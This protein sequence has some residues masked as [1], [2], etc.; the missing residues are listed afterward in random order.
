MKSVINKLQDLLN[1]KDQIWFDNVC[2]FIGLLS[3]ITAIASFASGLLRDEN[4]LFLFISNH[5]SIIL[6]VLILILMLFLVLKYR[7]SAINKMRSASLRTKSILKMTLY[8]IDELDR[9]KQRIDTS[10]S[11]LYCGH[12]DVLN[13]EYVL[14][15]SKVY[16]DYAKQ[17][18]NELQIVMKGFIAYDV[19]FCIKIIVGDE[20]D[21]VISLARSENTSADRFKYDNIETKISENSD[22]EILNKANDLSIHEPYFY[23]GNLDDYNEDLKRATKGTSEYKNSNSKWRDYYIGTMVVPISSVS[24]GEEESIITYG[25][26]CADSKDERAFS[27]RQKTINI[28][29]MNTYALLFGMVCRKYNSIMEGLSKYYE[30]QD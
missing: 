22:F 3:G 10:G 9:I 5:W 30:K 17:F 19:S 1:S 28:E 11:D 26:L 27:E 25:F 23:E 7:N 16:V 13:D 12:C 29:L 8:C 21:S 24:S 14:Q 18:I 6:F 4:N 20:K 2:K 15:V